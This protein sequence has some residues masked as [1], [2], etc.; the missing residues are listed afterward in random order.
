MLDDFLGSIYEH[1]LQPVSR[2]PRSDKHTEE[3]RSTNRETPST[4]DGEGECQDGSLFDDIYG[5]SDDDGNESDDEH[6]DEDDAHRPMMPTEAPKACLF[7]S[8]QYIQ[9]PDDGENAMTIHVETRHSMLRCFW[10]DHPFY[11]D[12]FETEA[13]DHLRKRH[14]QVL[15][16]ILGIRDDSASV[17]KNV[18][19]EKKDVHDGLRYSSNE[20][21]VDETPKTLEACTTKAIEEQQGQEVLPSLDQH[22]S[23]AAGLTETHMDQM[24]LDK[25]PEP[26][27]TTQEMVVSDHPIEA[28]SQE[29]VDNAETTSQDFVPSA[30]MFCSRCF[31]RVTGSAVS[32]SVTTDDMKVRCHPLTHP[33]HKTQFANFSSSSIL[34]PSAAVASPTS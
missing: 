24:D 20:E 25:E 4:M 10:C 8:C 33:L 28:V 22:H 1:D 14:R 12:G 18:V 3:E 2:L 11:R 19:A 32:G 21:E 17:A 5:R 6:E 26:L 23:E 31:R 7:Q 9:D 27:P 13:Q 34:T 16:Q 29:Q 30:N 15:L